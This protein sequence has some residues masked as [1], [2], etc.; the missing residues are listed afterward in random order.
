MTRTISEIR[1]EWLQA[2]AHALASDPKVNLRRRQLQHS[3]HLAKTKS[4]IVAEDLDAGG[5]LQGRAAAAAGAPA[6]GLDRNARGTS[7]YRG[8]PHRQCVVALQG[9]SPARRDK[10]EVAMFRPAGAGPPTQVKAVVM[11]VAIR[12]DLLRPVTDEELMRLSER[13]PG[14][15]F[16]RTA[17]GRLVVTPTGGESGRLSMEVAGQLH[18]WNKRTGLGVVFDSSTGFRLPDGSL[19]SPDAAWLPRGRW[20]ALTREER[21]G[22]VPLCPEAVFEVRSPSQTADELRE[23]MRAYLSNGARI[24]VL[25]DPYERAVE[26][27][28]PEREPERHANPPRV[29]LDP[30]LP[31]FA[32]DLEPVF[33]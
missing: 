6:P 26:V 27:Y 14:Y 20:E 21:K 16:E 31:G 4:V 10:I 18:A 12:L 9:L 28:R 32:L 3:T 1:P 2:R 29:A 23:K 30:E 11:P 22:F 8:R 25:V 24:A 19:L 15:Q 17:E 5:L 7:G 33:G 13:N